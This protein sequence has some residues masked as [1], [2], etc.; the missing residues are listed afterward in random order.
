MLLFIA[1]RLISML[2][3]MIVIS[4]I[5]FIVFEG[6]KLNVAGKV[7]GPYSSTD[8]RELWVEQNG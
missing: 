2:L 8:Q 6:D 5:L 1:R 4:L 7:L 3:I